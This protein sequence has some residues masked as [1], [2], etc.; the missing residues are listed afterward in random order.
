MSFLKKLLFASLTVFS[1]SCAPI[2][3]FQSP[4]IEDNFL[5][6]FGYGLLPFSSMMD[7]NVWYRLPLSSRWEYG[8][9]AGL[10][11]GLSIDLKYNFLQSFILAS[12][13]LS[14]T[15]V[16]GNTYISPMILVGTKRIYGGYKLAYP[17]TTWEAEP[18]R[19][20]MIG[21]TIGNKI[22]I[23]PE[24]N[25]WNELDNPKKIEV[26]YGLGIAFSISGKSKEKQK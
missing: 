26:T 2:S 6:G 9:R 13:D 4:A 7:I 10:F 23:M 11:E 1:F 16:E 17:I 21:A 24:I 12:G 22:R 20:I 18:L 3:T 25:F 8:M 14:F 15:P 19:I 5:I